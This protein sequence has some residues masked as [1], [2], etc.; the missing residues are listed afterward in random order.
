MVMN[1]KKTP[2]PSHRY[3]ICDIRDESLPS[4]YHPNSP[5]AHTDSLH[6]QLTWNCNG[7]LPDCIYLYVQCNNSGVLRA[8]LATGL[9]QPPALWKLP[10]ALGSVN[11]SLQYRI[12]IT[13]PWG[14]S[15][16]QYVS[17]QLS[18]ECHNCSRALN[19]IIFYSK[20][21]TISMFS[22]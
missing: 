4:W 5:P 12:F 10:F 8:N 14:P 22:A 3:N 9:H 20:Q 11:A 21:R 7:F 16:C 13:L 6:G 17:N 18:H 2:N 1:E 19:L 15:K